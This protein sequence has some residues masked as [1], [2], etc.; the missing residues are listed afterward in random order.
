MF[1]CFFCFVALGKCFLKHSLRW[2]FND[3]FVEVVSRPRFL[4][5]R[6]ESFNQP[7]LEF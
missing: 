7:L 2:F 4:K 3:V 6:S 1:L 5:S